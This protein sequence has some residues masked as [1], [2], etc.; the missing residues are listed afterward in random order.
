MAEEH[1]LNDVQVVAQREVLID[2]GDPQPLRVPRTV[3]VDRLPLP[4]D[5]PLVWSPD[6]GQS[7]DQNRL[8]GSVVSHQRSDL[9]AR[10]LEINRGE[11]LHR[12]EALGHAV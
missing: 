3:H 8:P 12:P 9:S 6:T 4:Q 1:V 10:N 11:C 2:R 5:L 7:S